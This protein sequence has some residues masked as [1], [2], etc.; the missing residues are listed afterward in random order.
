[1]IHKKKLIELGHI[2]LEDY[3]VDILE[4]FQS[5]DFEKS[6]SL[7][8]GL[9]N[10]QRIPFFEWLGKEKELGFTVN[11]MAKKFNIINGKILMLAA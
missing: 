2:C 5:E 4:S 6:K 3:F 1:M 10:S 11:S 9:G 8:D 7:Y